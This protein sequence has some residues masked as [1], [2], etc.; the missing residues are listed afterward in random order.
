MTHAARLWCLA[1]C[2]TRTQDPEPARASPSYPGTGWGLA[3]EDP[4]RRRGPGSGPDPAAPS[5]PP[6]WSASCPWPPSPCASTG[7]PGQTHLA[8]RRTVASSQCYQCMIKDVVLTV[9]DQGYGAAPVD[10]RGGSRTGHGLPGG[11]K[12]RCAPLQAAILGPQRPSLLCPMSLCI[13]SIASQQLILIVSSSLSSLSSGFHAMDQHQAS[14]RW[15]Q[16]DSNGLTWEFSTLPQAPRPCPLQRTAPATRSCARLPHPR[17]P[18]RPPP[19]SP[20]MPTEGPRQQGPG[21]CA[22]RTRRAVKTMAQHRGT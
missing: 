8:V 13:D 2:E 10:V 12:F 4:S 20:G 21:S 3:E 1:S 14:S 9:H 22:L 16:L 11:Q 5:D 7:S 19:T 6:A 17:L 15:Q 18:L